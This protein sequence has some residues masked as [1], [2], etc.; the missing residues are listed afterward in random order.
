MFS[1]ESLLGREDLADFAKRFNTYFGAS[2]VQRLGNMKCG[3]LSTGA[4]EK[5]APQL[6]TKSLNKATKWHAW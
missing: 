5:T 6:T 3:L 2:I 1:V 4:A